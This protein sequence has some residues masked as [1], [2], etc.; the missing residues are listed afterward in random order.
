M[1][2][3]IT[4]W[5]D[6]L[7]I[8]FY[9]QLLI[10]FLFLIFLHFTAYSQK[11]GLVL[12][13]GGS[14]GVA[15]IGVIKALEESQIPIDYIA[16]TSMGAVI[17]GL[18]AAGY[19][20]DELEQLVLSKDFRNW[21]SDEI[22]K[23]YEYYFKAPV[24]DASWVSF[25][26]DY[27][28]VLKYSLPVNVV[29]PVY[30]DFA[31]MEMFSLASAASG[32]DFDS[33]F[34]P[35]RCVASD[36]ENNM[37]V[38]LRKGNLGTA[39]RASMTYP[40][41]FKPIKIDGKLLF[42]GGMYNNFPS[43]VVYDDFF[44]DII[45]GSK[46]AGNTGPPRENDIISQVTSILM[47]NTDYSVICENGVLIE[48]G[49]VS[50]NVIDFSRTRE[51][52]DSGYVAAMRKIDEIRIFVHD[53]INAATRDDRRKTFL[54]KQPPLVIDSIKIS[55]LDNKQYIYVNRVLRKSWYRVKDLE[56]KKLSLEGI[57]PKYFELLAEN[58]IERVYP[59]LIYDEKSGFYDMH[60]NM[61]SEKRFM[62]KLGGNISSRAAN[63]IFMQLHYDSWN[64]NASSLYVNGY[65]GRFYSSVM[66]SGRVDFPLR[67]PF[68]INPSISYNIWDYFKTTTYFISD[69]TPSFLIEKDKHFSLDFGVPVSNTGVAKL[70]IELGDIKNEYYQNNEFS[71][72]DTADNTLFRFYSPGISYAI[73]TIDRKQYARNGVDFQLSLRFVNGRETYSPGSTSL[74]EHENT[75]YHNWLR[76]KLK[77][78]NYFE[79]LGPFRFGFYT[80]AVISNQ[81]LFNNYTASLLY[82]PAFQPTPES[83][84]L[85]LPNYRAY[86]YGA[87]GL[88]AIVT[89]MKNF[90]LRLESYIFAPYQKIIR[91]E[92]S[93]AAF[94]ENFTHYHFLGASTLVYQTPIGPAS[95][96]FSYYDK[97]EESF[98]VFF[99]FGYILFNR[100]ALD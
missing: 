7:I 88:K 37:S 21:V 53:S 81:P 4:L 78:D 50:V 47:E 49:V 5:L 26:F 39:V 75:S 2:G 54:N 40:F 31:M 85:F 35:F 18:Y 16:G 58:R 44:P 34:I 14:R 89:M 56:S 77:Y 92:G 19:T 48:P 25:K 64:K 97:I 93:Q 65:F 27:D 51:F 57:K 42:D 52:I 83:M 15:H 38:I 10:L 32:Y 70:A 30:M 20:P 63:S 36:I 46:V 98:N 29:S 79:K 82:A 71:R 1:N 61:T 69:K 90:E 55:G 67:F 23:R 8:M 13:G 99:N 22:D 17:G 95:L 80:E 43:N 24:P 41:Y 94:G 72:Y 76:I 66:L 28:T 60:L 45:I 9:R 87:F 3:E 84:T 100:K 59:E 6:E 91:G 96:S 33:L 62:L 68:Y 11:V 12:S 73:R 74:I 86:N